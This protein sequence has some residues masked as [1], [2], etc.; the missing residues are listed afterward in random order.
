MKAISDQK[1]HQDKY[2]QPRGSQIARMLVVTGRFPR[3]WSWSSR[4]G[5]N[6][7]EV[8]EGSLLDWTWPR[9]VG[10]WHPKGNPLISVERVDDKITGAKRVALRDPSIAGSCLFMCVTLEIHE[11]GGECSPK[12]NCNRRDPHQTAEA[13][14]RRTYQSQVNLNR[15][16]R[17]SPAV[18]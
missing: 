12:R 2:Q 14:P 10:S 9:N 11:R 7:K 3:V 4:L 6:A 15:S 1:E 18:L 8:Q 13:N 17:R 5:M 16:G